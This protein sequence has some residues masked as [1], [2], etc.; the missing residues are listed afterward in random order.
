M[1]KGIHVFAAIA[2]LLL[3]AFPSAAQPG[4]ISRIM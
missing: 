2:F 1:I 3:N 4:A